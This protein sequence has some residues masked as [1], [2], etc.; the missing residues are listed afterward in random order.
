MERSAA[1]ASPS[2]SWVQREGAGRPECGKGRSAARMR[3]RSR[4]DGAGA[5]ANALTKMPVLSPSTKQASVGGRRQHRRRLC[6]HGHQVRGLPDD[7]QRGAVLRR[8]REHRQRADR[9]CR[10]RS[11]FAS[12]RTRPTA[13]T[14]SATTRPSISPPCSRARSSSWRR[15]SSSTRPTARCLS[16]A[17][18]R[19]R[20]PASPST[21]WQPRS[22]PA[23]PGSSSPRPRL[24]IAGPG[25]RRPPSAS[26][27]SITSVGVLAGL[28][29]ATVTGWSILDPLLRRRGGAQHPAHGL[30]PRH[31][32]DEPAHGRGRLA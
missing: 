28:I 29:L 20:P 27:T 12:A 21:A 30:R 25:G 6:R 10:A 23:G 18:Y 17:A 14:R 2:D 32:L 24:E 31:S 26:A 15:S 5:T 1:H 11:P 3:W 19:A 16:R 7:G 8:A 13:A 4:L 22:T 9:H